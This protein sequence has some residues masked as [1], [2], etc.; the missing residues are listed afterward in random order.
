MTK[1]LRPRVGSLTFN[2]REGKNTSFPGKGRLYVLVI[3]RRK[4]R[5][6]GEGE[7]G[8][9]F[10]SGNEKKLSLGGGLPY[11]MI[12]RRGGERKKFF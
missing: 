9:S 5:A 2:G 6:L 1:G 8:P 10:R 12:R 7:K 3:K 4:D 11:E